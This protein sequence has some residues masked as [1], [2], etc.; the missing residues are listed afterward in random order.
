MGSGSAQK[1]SA[2]E[3]I[4]AIESGDRVVLPLCCGLP[5]TLMEALVAD[6]ARLKNVELVSGLQLEYKFLEAGFEDSF[7]FRTW[8]CA[9]PIRKLVDT[10]QVKYIPMRQGDAVSTFS[11]SGVWPVKRALIQAS[12]P[13][14]NGYMSLGVSIG[15]A[16]PLAL[17]AETVIVEA[18]EEMPRV[19]GESFIHTSQVDFIVETSRP[20]LEFPLPKELGEIDM[21][22]GECVA[23]LVPDSA[24]LQ[25]GIGAIPS[26]VIQSLKD[27]RDLRFFAMGVDGIV[28]LVEAGAVDPGTSVSDPAKIRVT[29]ILGTKRLF[30]FVHDN[31]MVEGRPLHRTINSRVVAEIERFISVLSAIEI[32]ITG[33]VNAET[34]RG[35][36]ISAIGGSFDF[37]QGALY[38]PGGKS[39][40]AMTATSPDGKHSRIVSS[41][42]LGSAVTTPRHCVEYVVTEFGVAD[43]KGKS[44]AE[45]AEALIGIA[46]PDFREELRGAK[47]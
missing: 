2:Q 43:L 29:E 41:L 39:I 21:K 38:S 37:L 36:Q 44:A 10:G 33:Q 3:A 11:R 19:L 22:I 27:K 30:D 47:A 5:Q 16:L 40:I 18:N 28:D 23:D 15:H 45:R 25:I 34:V 24:T 26:A 7:S 13:D 9:P 12:P 35:K 14:R 1:V 6:S 46:H 20:L 31:P 8:Q 42:P 4:Q 32:D 17:D